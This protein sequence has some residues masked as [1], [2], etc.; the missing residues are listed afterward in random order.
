[1]SEESWGTVRAVFLTLVGPKSAGKS[2]LAIAV[3]EYLRDLA[4]RRSD[5]T[6]KFTG[7]EGS[8]TLARFQ[9]ERD[10]VYVHRRVLDPTPFQEP[11]SIT[12]LITT[13]S[14]RL[15]LTIQD[16]AGEIFTNVDEITGSP[17]IRHSDVLLVIVPVSCLP[18]VGG[19]DVVSSTDCAR[20]CEAAIT[21]TERVGGYR[22]DQRLPIRAAM[23][24]A[25]ADLPQVKIALARKSPHGNTPTPA[26]PELLESM[27]L[28]DTEMS[29]ALHLLR[30]R[31]RSVRVSL[32]SALGVA[33]RPDGSLPNDVPLDPWGVGELL[34]WAL[35]EVGAVKPSELR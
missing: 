1:M 7:T 16:A 19:A 33:P 14:G 11:W 9:A 13:P 27:I 23:V 3:T 5:I 24:L 12:T 2:H 6:L 20:T 30:A 28:E 22:V 29:N 31:F 21:Y 4:Q 26:T 18:A 25:H 35:S 17:F 34:D 15:E 32:V 10:V 8:K